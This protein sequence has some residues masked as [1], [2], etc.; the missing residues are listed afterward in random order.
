MSVTT[1]LV[2]IAADSACNSSELA[3]LLWSM[4]AIATGA[5]LVVI[6]RPRW[7]G[8]AAL[9][10]A[11]L[12]WVWIEMEGP[13]LVEMGSHGIHLADIPVLVTAPALVIAAGRLWLRR[14]SG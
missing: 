4:I 10:A 9:V 7:V 1:S 12:L 11:D 5:G 8:L 14:R 3:R 2:T 13:T 6:V